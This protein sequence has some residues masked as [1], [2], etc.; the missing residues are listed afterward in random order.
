MRDKKIGSLP[1]LREK[2]LVGIITESDIF[3]AFVGLFTSDETGARITFD[4]SAGE[5]FF[6]LVAQAA[7]RNR[8]QVSSL[9]RLVQDNQ[10]ICVVRVAG[11]TVDSFLEEIWNSGHRVLNVIRFPLVPSE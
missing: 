4:V 1:V 10:P 6:A 9:V 5:D 2:Q 7:L 3:R 11:A 8:V